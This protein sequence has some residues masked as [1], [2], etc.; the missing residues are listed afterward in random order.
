MLKKNDIIKLQ[1]NDMTNLGFG[2]SRHEGLVVFVSGAVVGD[3]LDAKIIKLTSSYAIG[4]IE[5]M[6]KYSDK[7]CEN[8]CGITACK[9]CAYKNISYDFECEMKHDDVVAA[10]RKAELG[11]IEI[12]AV[13]PSPK[14]VNYRNKAQYPITVSK[15]GDYIIGFYAPK[16]HNVTEARCCP[17]APREF[18]EILE[19]LATFF[20]SHSLSCYNEK[21]GTGLLRHIYLRRGEIS[22]EIMLTL[23]I[24]GEKIP[25]VDELVEEL[26]SNHPQIKSFLLNINRDNTNVILGD[27]YVRVFGNEYISDTLSD[28]KLKLTAPSFYQVNHAQAEALYRKAKELAAP[29]KD[30]TLLDLYCGVGSIGLSMADEAGELIGIEIVDSAVQ[31]ARENA[32]KSGFANAKFYTGDA[33]DTKKML[34]GAERELGRKI[35]PNVIILDPPRAGC[36]PELI[37]F[38]SEL[39]P[40]RIVYISC[41]PQTL[42]RDIKLFSAHGYTAKEVFPYDMFPGTGHVEAV[43]RLT[44]K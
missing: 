37:E 29:R 24:N 7:R 25:H 21:D 5:K 17:L 9:S 27:K 8:R 20:K 1:I 26:N 12:H 11:D 44:R 39:S 36:A 42:A 19:T 2:V 30:D 43:C 38:V 35:E 6:H 22:G 34:A 41:N 15:N 33:K 40:E 13:A 4:K 3:E 28:V 14:L 23:V 10:F 32:E 31:M 18:P 16:S